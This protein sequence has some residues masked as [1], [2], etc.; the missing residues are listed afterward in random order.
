MSKKR[1]IIIGTGPAGLLAALEL[2]ENPNVEILMF[3]KGPLREERTEDNVI[4]GWGG[5]GA[6]S[7]GKLVLS[8]EIGGNLASVISRERFKELMEKVDR[9]F[10]KFGGH[11]ETYE[12][13]PAKIRELVEKASAFDLRLI[14]TKTRH[15]GSDRAPEIAKN[16]KKG[17]ENR[18]VQIYLETPV[19]S[20]R[21]KGNKFL[22]RAGGK[23]GGEYKA[24]YVIA[25]P[26]RDGADW[27]AVQAQR[28]GLVL[29]GQTV[30]DLGLRVEVP[31]HI[32]KPITDYIYDPKF[33]LKKT[34]C[35]GDKVRT[36]CVCPQGQVIIERYRG[37]LTTVN[38]HSYEQ[39]LSK[40]SNNTNFA[41]LVSITFDE[42]FRDPL[43]FG[44]YI[45]ELANMLSGKV[46]VQR[47]GD[48]TAAQERRSTLKRLE[49]TG[50]FITP[51]LK[52]AVPGDLGFAIPYR[53]MR[54]ILEMLER[55]N[56]VAPGVCS[57]HTLLYAP[58]VKFYS[59]RIE[60]SED[61]ETEIPGFFVAGDGAG[62]S[63]GILHASIS[64]IVTARSI[65]R[66][67]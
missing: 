14:P 45:A 49:E 66:R 46:M 63:R 32:F 42:P 9:T 38:G 30:V 21:K 59:S 44:K 36:F 65:L 26:G 11:Q 12:K 47:L 48:L 57:E 55:L 3:E 7:D 61:L 29:P 58:E 50:D 10:L 52:E 51:T 41:I 43:R 62:I 23:H 67:I 18:G 56:N 22:V 33:I 31:A 54:G 34:K 5:A 53:F 27:L 39:D 13:D 4:S 19:R 28:F 37:I 16:I 40:K 25:A 1:V 2:S 24:D 60:T 35:T 17:L 20:I 15:F 8:S 64:G 6:F